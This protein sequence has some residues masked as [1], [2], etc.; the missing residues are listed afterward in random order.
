MGGHP[1][2]TWVLTLAALLAAAAFVPTFKAE[3]IT[4]S[5][6]FLNETESVTGQEVLAKH[7][8]AGS[9]SPVQV[10]TPEAK[11]QQVIDVLSREDGVNDPYAGLAPGAPPKVVDGN[12]IVQAT[13]TAP[14]DSPEADDVVRR[15]RAD[16]DAVGEDVLVGGQTAMNL[17]VRDASNRDVRV[18]IPAILIVIFLVLALL[19]R[20]LVAPL[21]L[22]AANVI[23]FAATMGIAA[24]V[25]NHVFDFPG[26]DPSTPLYGFVFLVALGIDYSIFLMTRVREEAAKRGDPQGHPRRAGG[27]RR[28]HHECGHRPRG[29]L[30]G[31]GD[32]AA[33][34]PRPDRLHRRLRRPARHPRRALAARAGAGLRHRPE[35]LVAQPPLA[36]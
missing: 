34:V 4:Q 35:G 25:F 22:V 13:L 32:P 15:L 28:R 33:A 9:G 23:S 18:I 24:L 20:S 36:G 27:D 31:A 8:P 14:A 12:V 21:L 19:L 5:E 10:L 11:T 1:R 16:L 26:A 30:L 17:D 3:G 2:R 6:V 29:D 7:F